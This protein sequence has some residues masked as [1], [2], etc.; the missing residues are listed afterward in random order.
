MKKSLINLKRLNRR[1]LFPKTKK[2]L[3]SVR[4]SPMA[5]HTRRRKLID[6]NEV[7]HRFNVIKDVQEMRRQWALGYSDLEIR[8]RMKLSAEQ[9][10]K[11]LDTMRAVPPAD[12]TIKSFERD[13]LEHTKHGAKLERRQRRLNTI[14]D[15]AIEEIEVHNRFNAVFKRPRD[16]ELARATLVDLAAVDKDIIKAEQDLIQVKQKL[17]IID[18]TVAK[19]E[20]PGVFNVG[21]LDQAGALRKKQQL[22]PPINPDQKASIEEATLLPDSELPE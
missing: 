7:T 13:F 16:L 11:R 8:K 1:E 4:I 5:Y 17:G 12:D 15:N 6:R 19:V 3:K 14:Y 18:Q 22:A 10:R 20:I 9:W 2:V 21:V